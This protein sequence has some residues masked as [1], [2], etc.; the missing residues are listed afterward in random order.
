VLQLLKTVAEQ[1]PRGTAGAVSGREIEQL[2][3]ETILL[4]NIL[5]KI[6][7]QNLG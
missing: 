5:Q 3:D 1:T 4:A 7:M 6:L 2:I